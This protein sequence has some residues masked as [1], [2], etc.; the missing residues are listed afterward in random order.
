MYDST[1]AKAIHHV[2]TSGRTSFPRAPTWGALLESCFPPPDA[3]SRCLLFRLI[4]GSQLQLAHLLFSE[5]T[6]SA[7][8]I[9]QSDHS[10]GTKTRIYFFIWTKRGSAGALQALTFISRA[11]N[12]SRSPLCLDLLTRLKRIKSSVTTRSIS[13][14]SVEVCPLRRGVV[15][16]LH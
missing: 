16:H 11:E 4:T 12:A 15:V 6:H 7:V 3:S 2:C 5:Q 13:A 1:H 14:E 10:L 9:T 8:G